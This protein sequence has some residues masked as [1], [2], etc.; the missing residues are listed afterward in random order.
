[1]LNINL[2]IALIVAIWVVLIAALVIWYLVARARRRRAE[3]D[4]PGPV[5]RSGGVDEPRRDTPD[6][7]AGADLTQPVQRLRR[8]P[9][10][11]ADRDAGPEPFGL[12]TQREYERL[13][14]EPFQAPPA[15]ELG[16][17]RSLERFSWAEAS[18]SGPTRPAVARK[19]T[20]PSG[21][22]GPVPAVSSELSAEEAAPNA[23][24]HRPTGITDEPVAP[25]PSR[26]RS[27]AAPAGDADPDRTVVVTRT[28]VDE[29]PFD[30]A[31]LLPD[32]DLLPLGRDCVVGR[33]PVPVDASTTVVIADPTRT[34]SKSHARL[35]FDG[36]RWWV[37][38]L[39][40]TNGLW[41]LHANGDEEEVRAREEVE[42]TPRLRLG[43]LDVEL[44]HR[45]P[46]T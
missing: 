13:A 8:G 22:A 26:D 28:P 29:G 43:T 10:A 21:P 46:S 40:S 3:S 9:V 11:P 42:A 32:G 45:K 19:S 17:R 30:W 24:V 4:L 33:R 6:L 35:R 41:L 36:S 37:T 20:G 16:Q 34:L 23:A 38:D 5:R 27:G 39:D 14:S 2:A 1:M 31:L 25:A 18:K 15:A 44:Y 7:P 12:T